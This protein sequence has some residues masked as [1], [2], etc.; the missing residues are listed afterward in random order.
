MEVGCAMETFY[1]QPGAALTLQRPRCGPA[2]DDVFELIAA[3]RFDFKRC[4][5][6]PEIFHFI[7]TECDGC[8]TERVLRWT[9]RPLFVDK[10][11]NRE[12]IP[13]SKIFCLS[14]EQTGTRLSTAQ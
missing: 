9:R 14:N 6:C 11:P 4:S 13:S 2:D 5:S 7:V 8:G 3:S 12:S 10:E 1:T